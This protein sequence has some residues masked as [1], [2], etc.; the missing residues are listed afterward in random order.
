[1]AVICCFVRGWF[2]NYS[3]NWLKRPNLTRYFCLIISLEKSSHSCFGSFYEI[4]LK[5]S[6]V[7]FFMTFWCRAQYEDPF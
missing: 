1:M 2:V 4:A 7:A 5:K 6:F 3:I